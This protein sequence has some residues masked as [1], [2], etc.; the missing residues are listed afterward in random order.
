MIHGYQLYHV[1]T[2]HF[3]LLLLAPSLV[4][5][6]SDFITNEE[7]WTL[8]EVLPRGRDL[9][10]R[11]RFGAQAPDRKKKGNLALQLGLDHKRT[12]RPEEEWDDGLDRQ[13]QAEWD[14][15]TE[16]TARRT[17]SSHQTRPN[18]T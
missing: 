17:P 8:I 3:I 6:S 5:F 1:T 2:L 12:M 11:T 14:A 4:I 7:L 13:R 15:Q 9:Y 18:G 16:G 10:D